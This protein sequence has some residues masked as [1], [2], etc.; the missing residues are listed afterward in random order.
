[1]HDRGIII[2]Q[3]WERIVTANPIVVIPIPWP[4]LRRVGHP[5]A[6]TISG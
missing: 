3:Q 1:M 5:F 2:A 4:C 6:F